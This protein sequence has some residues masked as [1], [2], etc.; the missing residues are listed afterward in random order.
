MLTSAETTCTENTRLS[1]HLVQK[2]MLNAQQTRILGISFRVQH[3]VSFLQSPV[4]YALFR[5]LF[6][7]EK[8]DSNGSSLHTNICVLL[9]K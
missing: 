3:L 9:T 1:T 6:M 4:S 2:E 5:R 7:T 8:T